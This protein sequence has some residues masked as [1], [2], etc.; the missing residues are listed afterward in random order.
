M[1]TRD[2]KVK[3]PHGDLNRPPSTMEQDDAADSQTRVGTS[4]QA[5]ATQAV[6]D[7]LADP[8][9]MIEVD[10]F[11]SI[12]D[13]LVPVDQLLD[14]E[15][16]LSAPQEPNLGNEPTTYKNVDLQGVSAAQYSHVPRP[17]LQP[18]SP[19]SKPT[20][21]RGR[22]RQDQIPPED[23]P[24][25][26]NWFDDEPQN[27]FSTSTTVEALN[28]PVP[29]YGY[30]AEQ[31]LDDSTTYSTAYDP[32]GVP[33]GPLPTRTHEGEV[34][35]YQTDLW[36]A[37]TSLAQPSDVFNRKAQRKR[38]ASNFD[39]LDVRGKK[40]KASTEISLNALSSL[41]NDPQDQTWSSEQYLGRGQ[42][43][44][45]VPATQ[46]QPVRRAGQPSLPG[47]Y[48]GY[49]A[50]SAS[51]YSGISQQKSFPHSRP[52]YR[53]PPAPEDAYLNTKQGSHSE[54][55]NA[56]SG[57]KFHQGNDRD[58]DVL[59][60]IH[61]EVNPK[62]PVDG[63]QSRGNAQNPAW[64][65]QGEK[66]P[67]RPDMSRPGPGGPRTWPGAWVTLNKDRKKYLSFPSAREKIPAGHHLD[68]YCYWFPNHILNEGLDH[69]IDNGLN[70]HYIWVRYHPD[71]TAFCLQKETRTSGRP[72]NFLEQAMS[73]RKTKKI[74]EVEEVEEAEDEEEAEE[75]EE[76]EEDADAHADDGNEP[77]KSTGQT[78][79]K[80][81][82]LQA[83]SGMA[84][85]SRTLQARAAHTQYPEVSFRPPVE[86]QTGLI[87]PNENDML[88]SATPRPLEVHNTEN[89]SVHQLPPSAPW[90]QIPLRARYARVWELH[91]N[92]DA[93]FE[94]L[95]EADRR[96]RATGSF[97]QHFSAFVATA[98]PH[99][100][101]AWRSGVHPMAALRV[102]YPQLSR[103]DQSSHATCEQEFCEVWME[104]FLRYLDNI[105]TSDEAEFRR[106]I[107]T[108]FSSTRRD[109]GNAFRSAQE[110]L[111]SQPYSRHASLQPSGTASAGVPSTEDVAGPDR[112]RRDRSSTIFSQN[113]QGHGFAGLTQFLGRFD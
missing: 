43:E 113:H 105:I 29:A 54:P 94:Q 111:H 95:A 50:A 10:T 88:S 38:R 75:A 22:E 45:S 110:H 98:W 59:P 44:S 36:E 56:F 26:L 12:W 90:Y 4:D 64:L 107:A 8:S 28:Y 109:H 55:R 3:E 92:R 37:Q 51:T 9:W 39:E 15:L 11:N 27:Y 23:N 35:Q 47:S 30:P 73:R 74:A 102:I 99:S 18:S 82:P 70:G 21:E 13:S 83:Q 79:R 76:A 62:I 49:L 5:S 104:Y 67:Q 20:A 112:T 71:A 85:N 41:D 1:E 60:P 34:Y 96:A 101:P 40:A 97:R 2:D 19:V 63:I 66:P 106:A 91:R 46:Y 25:L 42:F 72:W 86:R 100:T 31:K 87:L 58:L 103:R 33:F 84:T 68:V 81:Q 57:Q 16:A 108:C 69:F 80:G 14:N 48:H 7:I 61:N 24:Q 52:T 89:L 65:L 77:T 53:A 78:Q 93:D 6:E 17:Y 32:V